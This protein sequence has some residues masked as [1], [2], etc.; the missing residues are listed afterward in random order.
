[1]SPPPAKV[2][3]TTPAGATLDVWQA[4]AEGRYDNDDPRN[5]PDEVPPSLIDENR[6]LL[7]EALR[8]HGGMAR[9]EMGRHTGLSPA[10]I[11]SIS[12][13]LISDGILEEADGG[14]PADGPQR[15]GRP[16]RGPGALQGG[17]DDGAMA[18][19]DAVEVPDGNDRPP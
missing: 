2:R 12:S 3:V 18:A 10:S 14:A 1:M 4:N 9:V 17:A 19:M 6:L 8:Q 5:P 16:V 7:L 11:T 15:R 13:Q